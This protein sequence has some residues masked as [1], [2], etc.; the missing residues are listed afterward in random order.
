MY[1]I[2]YFTF[3]HPYMPVLL[4]SPHK[5]LLDDNQVTTWAKV[6]HSAAGL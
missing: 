2:V 5:R 4:I 3:Q 6:V 1:T